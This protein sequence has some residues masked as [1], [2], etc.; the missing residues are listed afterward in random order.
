MKKVLIADDN[1]QNREIAKDVLSSWGYTCY[2]AVNG[3]EVLS[4]ACEHDPDVILLDV[5]MPGMNGFEVCRKLKNT[6]ATQNIPVIMLTVLTEVQDKI[7]GYSAGTDIFLSKPIVYEELKNRLE[8]AVKSKRAYSRMEKENQVAQSYLNFMELKDRK[9]FNHACNVKHYCEK[10][11]K[12]LSVDDEEFIHLQIGAY[13][14]DIGKL[15]CGDRDEHV[16][17]GAEIMSSLNM[18]RWLCAFIRNHHEQMNGLGFP[19]HLTANQMSLELKILI[20]VN[21]FIELYEQ[22]GSKETGLFV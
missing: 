6:V 4:S 3:P 17:L 22:T 14:H 7:R 5:M 19:D 8:W 10:V 11:G 15:L 1:E 12:I 21:R 20:T 2:T 13:L 16:L 9:L 18:H